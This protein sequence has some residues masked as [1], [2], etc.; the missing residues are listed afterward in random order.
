MYY[1]HNILIYSYYILLYFIA[2]ILFLGNIPMIWL[3][4]MNVRYSFLFILKTHTLF[5][6][7][8]HDPKCLFKMTS[9]L[10]INIYTTHI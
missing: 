7:Y 8:E 2:Y 6:F 5:I 1:C 9:F 4:T 10:Q 3:Q